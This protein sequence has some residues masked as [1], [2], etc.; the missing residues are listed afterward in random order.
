MDGHGLACTDEDQAAR[1]LREPRRAA[2]A[3][4]AF[5][6]QCAAEQRGLAA[7]EQR[8]RVELVQAGGNVRRPQQMQLQAEAMS[9]R[10]GDVPLSGAVVAHELQ[11]R[12]RIVT[13]QC[14]HRGFDNARMALGHRRRR[15]MHAQ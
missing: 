11:H 2:R 8:E 15:R 10:A 9:D 3:V 12:H 1:A 6:E 13:L 4:L 14:L 7:P 5:D